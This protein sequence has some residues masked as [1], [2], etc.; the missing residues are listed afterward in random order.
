METKGDVKEF[1]ANDPIFTGGPIIAGR[2]I[3]KR[4]F[5][6]N[7]FLP[8]ETDVFYSWQKLTGVVAEAGSLSLD[9]PVFTGGALVFG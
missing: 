3:G 4:G 8:P 6:G 9:Q 1:E 7:R 2:E 5:S